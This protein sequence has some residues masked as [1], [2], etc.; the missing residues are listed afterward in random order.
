MI[1]ANNDLE[2]VLK[3]LDLYKGKATTDLGSDKL[4]YRNQDYKR[5]GGFN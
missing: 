4:Y 1:D 5:P 2:A 3:W